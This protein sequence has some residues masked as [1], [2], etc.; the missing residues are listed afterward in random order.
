MDMSDG[1]QAVRNW[2]PAAQTAPTG[3]SGAIRR[4]FETKQIEYMEQIRLYCRAVPGKRTASLRFRVTDGRNVTMYLR[5]GMKVPREELEAFTPEGDLRPGMPVPDGGLRDAIL[6]YRS[7]IH[8]A[9][10]RMRLLGMNL[11][12]EVLR[13]EVQKM[14]PRPA[15]VPPEAPETLAGRYERFI[16]DAYRDGVI[17][18]NRY[19]QYQG[20]VRRLRRFLAIRGLSDLAPGDFDVEL[21]L[22]YRCFVFNEYQYVPRYASLYPTVGKGRQRW[23]VKRMSAN[24]VVHEMKALKTFFNEMESTGEVDRSPFRKLSREKRKTMMHVMYNAPFFLRSDEFRTILEAQLPPELA[25]VRDM[26]VLNCCL[27]CRIGD[28]SELT[29]SRV[30]V[31][32]EGIPFVH[33]FPSKIRGRQGTNEE[34]QT[35]LVRVAFDIVCRTR[36]GFNEGNARSRAARY[37]RL[38]PVLLRHCGI[39]RKVCVYDEEKRDNVYKPLWMLAT[40]RLARK[41]HVDMMNKVQINVYAAGLHSRGSDAVHRYTNMELRDRFALM[42]AAFGQE[43]FAVDRQLTVMAEPGRRDAAGQREAPLCRTLTVLAR[44]GRIRRRR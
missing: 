38:L 8:A 25:P 14:M 13:E 39:D 3:G 24:S 29:M 20:K 7:M 34:I 33:Y 32:P 12:S 27:G 1:G 10:G 19:V 37:N 42:N 18:K 21:L 40:S 36:F 43:T 17:G 4:E 35:P 44:K 2:C 6:G 5:T 22:E 30:D 9:Y 31:S 23:P 26:F 41:T 28:F 15:E 16:E 11:R